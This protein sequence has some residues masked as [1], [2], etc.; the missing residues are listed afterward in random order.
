MMILADGQRCYVQDGT[1]FAEERGSGPVAS[2]DIRACANDD[3]DLWFALGSCVLKMFSAPTLVSGSCD[4]RGRRRGVPL[5]ARFSNLSSVMAAAAGVF[6][7]VD[8]DNQLIVGNAWN[9]VDVSFDPTNDTKIASMAFDSDATVLVVVVGDLGLLSVQGLLTNSTYL[10]QQLRAKNYYP[11]PGVSCVAYV[12]DKFLMLSSSGDVLLLLFEADQATI[13][14]VSVLATSST[15]ACARIH[16][17]ISHQYQKNATT[18]ASSCLIMPGYS[19]SRPCAPGTFSDNSMTMCAACPP[20]TIAP[21]PAAAACIACPANRFS[22]AWGIACVDACPSYYYPSASA[23]TPC[24]SAGYTWAGGGCSPCPAMTSA[25]WGMPCTPCPS[26]TVADEGSPECLP[27][28]DPATSG[29]TADLFEAFTLAVVVQ[30]RKPYAVAGGQNGTLWIGCDDGAVVR[31]PPEED[32]GVVTVHVVPGSVVSVALTPMEDLLYVFDGAHISRI[33]SLVIVE[34]LFAVPQGGTMMCLG[35]GPILYW[36]SG[37]LLVYAYD[38]N[39][40]ASTLVTTGGRAL[41]IAPYPNGGGVLA[42]IV[43]NDPNSTTTAVWRVLSPAV[44]FPYYILPPSGLPPLQNVAWMTCCLGSHDLVLGFRD[45]RM[46]VTANGTA[47][48]FALGAAVHSDNLGTLAGFAPP[49]LAS[50]TFCFNENLLL[51]AEPATSSVRAIFVRRPWECPAGQYLFYPSAL[52]GAACVPCPPGTYSSIGALGCSGCP[53]GQYP[54]PATGECVA[55]PT[56]RWWSSD[57]ALKPC[58]P[59]QDTTS[60]AGGMTAIMTLQD[61]QALVSPSMPDLVCE[62]QLS[63]LNPSSQS[64]SNFLILSDLLGPVWTFAPQDAAPTKIMIRAVPGIWAKCCSVAL[65]GGECVCAFGPYRLGVEDAPWNSARRKRGGALSDLYI[66]CLDHSSSTVMIIM[67]ISFDASPITVRSLPLG[68]SCYVGWPAQYNCTLPVYAWEYPTALHPLGQCYACSPGTLAPDPSSTVC[69]PVSDLSDEG[70]LQCDAGYYLVF[71]PPSAGLKRVCVRCPSEQ[72]FSPGGA[73]TTSCSPKTVFSCPPNYYLQV[74]VDTDNECVACTQC[75]LDQGEI[76][77]PLDGFPCTGITTYQPYACYPAEGP[78][79]AGYYLTPSSLLAMQQIM[80]T[81]VSYAPCGS[82]PPTGATWAAGPFSELCY[83]KCMYAYNLDGAR[84]YAIALRLVAG[85]QLDATMQTAEKYNLFPYPPTMQHGDLAVVVDSV[86]AATCLCPQGQQRLPACTTS[87]LIHPE[88]CLLSSSAQHCAPLCPNVPLNSDVIDTNCTWRCSL[89][90][91]QRNASWCAPCVETSCAVGEQFMGCMGV[92]ACVPCEPTTFLNLSLSAPGRCAY[93]CNAEQLLMKNPDPAAAGSCAPCFSPADDPP[94]PPGQ[95]FSACEWPPCRPCPEPYNTLGGTAILAP[96]HDAVCRVQ[97]KTGYRTI[98]IMHN[99]GMLIA[100]SAGYYDPLDIFCEPCEVYR[101]YAPPN[102]VTTF[103]GP[104]LVPDPGNSGGCIPCTQTC[105]AGG[106]YDCQFQECIRCPLGLLRSA[107]DNTPGVWP[108]RFFVPPGIPMTAAVI[109]TSS[110]CPTACVAGSVWYNGACI[111]CSLLLPTPPP[112]APY[113]A[114][115]ALFNARPA[116]RWWPPDFDP[117]HL[118]PRFSSAATPEKRAGVCWPCPLGTAPTWPPNSTS[119]EPCAVVEQ[120]AIIAQD[121]PDALAALSAVG[122]GRRLLQQQGAAAPDN[123]D[124][125]AVLLR[126]EDGTII[127][128][129]SPGYK[130]ISVLVGKASTRWWCMPCPTNY[131]CVDGREYLCP[132]FE[133]PDATQQRCVCSPGFRNVPE[134]G[135]KGCVPED[136]GACPPG[137]TIRDPLKSPVCVPCPAFAA[138]TT[139]TSTTFGLC[140]ATAQPTTRRRECP[141]IANNNFTA[142]TID[143]NCACGPGSEWTN[144]SSSC[145]PCAKGKVSRSVGYAPCTNLSF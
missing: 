40:N 22:D 72:Y 136:L 73:S 127:F 63:L 11:L 80:M 95:Y 113:A 4:E 142:W 140:T 30:D 132:M 79:V 93:D 134:G 135:G 27:I 71:L 54:L 17:Y 7:V 24:E 18:N 130:L 69:S 12:A 44:S 131:Y 59:M 107:A 90:F 43:N 91:F 112:A 29:L 133:V 141:F 109:Q 67:S 39:R 126:T 85:Q 88:S 25:A 35:Q 65:D 84:Q 144:A 97:C 99:T 28:I 124:S 23:C 32:T 83:F 9:V 121:A 76:A 2:G 49:I 102:C 3:R 55:C 41:A 53:S 98:S 52:S 5:Y 15:A 143:G 138:S 58:R 8:D 48:A 21:R 105:A 115:F 100:P 110:S 106:Y 1:L 82:A 92:Q 20:G 101:P 60:G 108:S 6:A 57:S 62:M 31:I 42:V 36:I 75:D 10:P 33:H 86:C 66:R 78:S 77:L 94:C 119:D 16:P 120:N 46:L 68:S 145:T 56:S 125:S 70:P 116:A 51:L 118:P 87:C 104:S 47:T 26:G 122:G 19:G 123:N 139:T 129:C 117:P 50:P 14:G 45:G 128:S 13:R 74:R 61:A 81:G 34:R 103:C 38:P 137:H 111:A 114:Y 64:S 96:S 37:A 89:G